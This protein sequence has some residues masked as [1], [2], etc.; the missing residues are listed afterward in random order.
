[1]HTIRL[2]SRVYVRL[3]W[4]VK[5]DLWP[6]WPLI[7]QMK[8]FKVNDPTTTSLIVHALIQSHPNF[9]YLP[10]REEHTLNLTARPLSG[11]EQTIKQSNAYLTSNLNS[12]SVCRIH[13]TTDPNHPKSALIWACEGAWEGV[14]CMQQSKRGEWG[15][16]RRRK[17]CA[18]EEIKFFFGL[19]SSATIS[20]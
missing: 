6:K 3:W 9:T 7:T 12:I 5:Y 17:R 4:C 19:S 11:A 10:E 13:A 8:W 2:L 18:K 20:D 1:M 16:N 14:L 15:E